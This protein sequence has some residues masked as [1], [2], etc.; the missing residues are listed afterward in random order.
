VEEAEAVYRA[1][2]GLDGTLA[3]AYQ[4]PENVWSLHGYHEC[5]MRLGKDDLAR[6]VKQRLDL[7]SARADVPIHSSCYC[8]LHHAA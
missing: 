6:V 8:R 1:D 7:A 5:L 4:H 2:L 3:R